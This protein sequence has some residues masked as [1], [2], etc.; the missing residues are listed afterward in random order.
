MTHR[1]K[2]MKN[3]KTILAETDLEARILTILVQPL[4]ILEILK[5]LG[6]D[7]F[8]NFDKIELTLERLKRQGLIKRF[9]INRRTHYQLT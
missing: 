3:T 6:L 1:V 5:S 8:D 4:N 7:D 9:D 2:S